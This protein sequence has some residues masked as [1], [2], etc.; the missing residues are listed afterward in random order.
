[1]ILQRWQHPDRGA[2]IDVPGDRKSAT[3]V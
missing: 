3:A 1:M 2:G